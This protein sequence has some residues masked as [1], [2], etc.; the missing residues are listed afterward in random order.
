LK[1]KDIQAFNCDLRL[2]FAQLLK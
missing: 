1:Q 2:G